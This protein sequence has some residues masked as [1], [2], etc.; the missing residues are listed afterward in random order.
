MKGEMV[1]QWQPSYFQLT[2]DFSALPFRYAE[3]CQVVKL[4]P[5]LS[6]DQ[7]RLKLT[8]RYGK[9]PI[10][11][12]SI[13]IANRPDF[14]SAKQLKAQGGST[15]LIE[16][17]TV[18]RTDPCPFSVQVGQAVYIKMTA[19]HPQIYADFA[20]TYQTSLVNAAVTRSAKLIPQL[21][22]KWRARKGWFSLES[23]EVMTGVHPWKI[24]I[25]GDSLVESG[26]VTA[27]L[28][29][30]FNQHW[31]NRLVWYQTGI[32]GNQLV[33]DAPVEEP[34]Y[35]TFGRGLLSRYQGLAIHRDLTIAVIGT[36]DLIMPY[37]SRTIAAQNMTPR[38]LT[39]GFEQFYQSCRSRGS[40][41]LTTTIAPIQLFDLSNPLPAEQIIDQQRE[42][43]N[44][45]LRQRSWVV[46]TAAFLTNQETHRLKE[47]FDFG[48]HLHWNPQGGQQVA[49]QLAQRILK[50][51]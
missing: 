26:M 47:R 9:L 2:H 38:V 45:W 12:D 10:V 11:F 6:G 19:N 32:S 21:P 25:T 35:E 16:P 13:M 42:Q 36:N 50:F 30:A 8:N 40:Q 44:Q 3:L 31:P 23:L 14:K 34:L 51:G 37:Y 28:I 1:M 4:T 17:G 5:S 49:D 43:V 20:A 22:S 29:E 41:V 46:D 33:H 48:D 39:Q 18:M 15:V 24:E 7:I 27:P